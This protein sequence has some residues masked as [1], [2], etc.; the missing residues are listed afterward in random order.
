[1]FYACRRKESVAIPKEEWTIF[2]GDVVQVMVGKD[3]GKTGTV[4]HVI[5]ETNAVFVMGRHTVS[6]TVISLLSYFFS[7]TLVLFLVHIFAD[8]SV[9][10]VSAKSE[11]VPAFNSL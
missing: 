4:S 9:V 10:E 2:P 11:D 5:R 7:F 1:M 6:F 3:K 8:N